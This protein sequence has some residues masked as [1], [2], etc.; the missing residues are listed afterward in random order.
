MQHGSLF[1]NQ[2]ELRSVCRSASELQ[3]LGDVGGTQRGP[4][5]NIRISITSQFF[6][7]DLNAAELDLI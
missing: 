3:V 4:K 7:M 2:G 1:S 5:I 6:K